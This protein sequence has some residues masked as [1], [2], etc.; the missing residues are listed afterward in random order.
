[1]INFLKYLPKLHA[2][3][4]DPLVEFPLNATNDNFDISINVIVFINNK[5][6][7]LPDFEPM[8]FPS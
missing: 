3:N 7:F 8:I 2:F 4:F 5:M 1:M 6:H